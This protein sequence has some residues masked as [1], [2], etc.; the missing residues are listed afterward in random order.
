MKIGIKTSNI[1]SSFIYY[2]RAEFHRQ[3]DME[4]KYI[5]NECLEEIPLSKVKIINNKLVCPYCGHTLETNKFK[6]ESVKKL[7][8]AQNDKEE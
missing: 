1:S 8:E 6:V 7:Q 5:C 2:F 4:N 3:S